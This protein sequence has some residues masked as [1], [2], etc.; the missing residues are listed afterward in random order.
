M[1]NETAIEF[2]IQERRVLELPLKGELKGPEVVALRKILDTFP[3]ILDVAECRY[4][5]AVV[6]HALVTMAQMLSF[7]KHVSDFH[8]PSK[9]DGAQEKQNENI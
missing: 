5:S 6:Q 9:P 4:D 7:K 1:E 8:N 2:N 3:L